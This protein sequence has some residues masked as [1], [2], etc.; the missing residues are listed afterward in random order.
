MSLEVKSSQN[1]KGAF[2][3]MHFSLIQSL[4]ALRKVYVKKLCNAL[5]SRFHGDVTVRGQGFCVFVY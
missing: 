5:L 4:S 2:K 3:K 1:N